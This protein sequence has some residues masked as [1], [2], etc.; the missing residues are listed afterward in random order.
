MENTMKNSFRPAN[1]FLTW[2]T[3]TVALLFLFLVTMSR[4]ANAQ[5]TTTGS[6]I[7]NSN[8]GNVGIGT[9]GAPS[10]GSL[11]EVKK[12][13][14]AGTVISIDNPFT[15]ASNS[16]YSGV[17][18]KQAG[19]N[20]L[21]VS[22]VNDN[23]SFIPAGTAQFWNFANA[24]IVFATNSTEQMRISSTGLVG[25]GTTN[26]LSQL[27]FGTLLNAGLKT[28]TASPT[29]HGFLFSSYMDTTSPYR[30]Y[31]D[32]VAMSNQDGISGGSTIRFLT[33]PHNSFTALER[34][35]IDY[36][37]NVGIGATAP[38]NLLHI[39]SKTS[40]SSQFRITANSAGSLSGLAYSP[41][42]AALGFDVDWNGVGWIARHSTLAALYKVGGKLQ[43]LGWTG[44]TV[45][46]PIPDW[47]VYTSLDLISGKFGIGVANPA[48]KLD[49]QNGQINSSGGL[50]IAGDCKTT[51]SAVGGSQWT[52]SSSIYFNTGNV[53]IGTAATPTR[54]LE[55]LGGNI[56]HE[57]ST[58]TG[59]EYGFYTALSNNHFTSNLSFDGQ[60]K[61]IGT[62]KGSLI[63]TGPNNGNNAFAVYSDNTSR[64][65]NAAATLTQLVAVTMDGN[66]GVGLNAT[67]ASEKLEVSGN[68]KVS[69][70]GNITA[71]GTI[72]GTNVKA[73]YQDVAEWVDSSQELAAGTVVVLDA[74]VSNQVIASTHAYDSG[75]AGV[76]S[77]QPGIAL[78][79]HGEGRVLVATTGRVKVKVDAS[80]GPIKIGDLLVTSDKEGVAMKSIPIEVGGARIHRPG[81][82]IGKALEPLARGTG[83]ILV[84]LSLQ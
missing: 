62:G 29:N 58:T 26:P 30:R 78:G 35:R 83:E 41:D 64:A 54:K 21:L 34:M 65:A 3:V 74:N 76:I 71:A 44:A 73:R 43:V 7:Y 22:S 40:P 79:E 17:L 81:T 24:P 13:Q 15:T 77:L 53:G 32:I 37:G 60:W 39:N 50:C 33:N 2:R 63:V 6:D 75:V 57:F 82:L 27:H 10:A 23:H 9:G 67:P 1:S 68:I 19:V 49:V 25:I 48:Y 72:E 46:S 55:V 36:L 12:S 8:S 70:T 5:W 38:T 11:L 52:G 80:K 42:N 51:W 18:F 4:S 56:F 69:G 16:A 28:Y 59:S 45:G 14:S 61:M 47:T 84:L 20:R 66:M 31:A